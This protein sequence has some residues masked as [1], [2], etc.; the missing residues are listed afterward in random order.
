MD[1]QI[2][3]VTDL[4]PAAATTAAAGANAFMEHLAP[5]LAR[6]RSPQGLLLAAG[7]AAGVVGGAY[8]AKA[9][10]LRLFGEEVRPMFWGP[11]P[12]RL[13]RPAS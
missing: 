10:S 5:K 4:A 3:S 6:I 7:V 1:T 13:R 2:T 9:I 12:I 11:L 8:L